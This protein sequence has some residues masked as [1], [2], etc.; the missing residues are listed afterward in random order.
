MPRR[1]FLAATLLAVACSS[2]TGPGGFRGELVDPFPNL[3]GRPFGVAVAPNGAVFVTHQDNQRVTRLGPSLDAP[4]ERSTVSEDPG[5]VIVTPDGRIAVVSTYFGGKL[6]FLDAATGVQTDSTLIGANAYRLALSASGADVFVTTVN[7]QVFR[8]GIATGEKLDSVQLGGALQGIARRH[9]GRLAVSSTAGRIT[10]LDPATLDTIRTRTVPGAAQE[11]VFSPD[12]THLYVAQEGA[13]R[14]L[15]L[16]GETLADVDAVYFDHLGNV[17]PFGMAL[18]PDGRTLLVA[19]SDPAGVAVVNTTTLTATRLS[20]FVGLARRVAFAP[21]GR[22]AYV[23]NE[24]GR[25][26]VVR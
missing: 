13:Q 23:A 8:V 15:V 26:E 21:N 2:A 22:Q 6:H 16:D 25:L 5:D 11:V 20:A 17:S 14:V 1:H 24:A 9:D 3:P 19:S 7:G 12:G 10:L 18:S 4:R